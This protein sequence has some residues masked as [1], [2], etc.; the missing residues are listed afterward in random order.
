VTVTSK[1]VV[2]TLLTDTWI[3][4]ALL[5]FMESMWITPD[6]TSGTLAKGGEKVTWSVCFLSVAPFG[7]VIRS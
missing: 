4:V 3:L 2:D 7:C 1:P 5:W 6:V